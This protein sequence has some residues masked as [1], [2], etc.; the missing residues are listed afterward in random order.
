MSPSSDDRTFEARPLE[1]ERDAATVVH[2]AAAVVEDAAHVVESAA[3]VVEEAAAVLQET[4]TTTAWPAVERRLKPRLFRR[5][6]EARVLAWPAGLAR[7]YA[8]P[9][10]DL[11]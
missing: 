3:A 7:Q 6:H 1:R 5:R 9:S 4:A 11:E 2:D 8:R 10:L